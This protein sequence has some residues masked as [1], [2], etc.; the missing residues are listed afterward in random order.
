MQLIISDE[1]VRITRTAPPYISFT[2]THPQMCYAFK[3][4]SDK[5]IKQYMTDRRIMIR[6]LSELYL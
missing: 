4:Y 6:Q 2:F 3:N 1:H 5:L